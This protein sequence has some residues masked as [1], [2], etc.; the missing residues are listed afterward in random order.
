LNESTATSLANTVNSLDVT[1]KNFSE[2]SV[3]L[4]NESEQLAAVIRNANSITTNI[5]DNNQSISNIIKNAEQTTNNLSAAPIQETVKELQSAAQQLDGILRKINNNEGSLGMIVNDKQLYGN[6][7]ET[8]KTL[9]DL[10][11]DMN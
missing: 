10:M 5:A 2:L 1:M 11:A 8:M 9:N 7:N 3:K 4:N 6:L